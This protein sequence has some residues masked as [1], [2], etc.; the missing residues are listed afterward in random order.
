MLLGLEMTAEVVL[1]GS[2]KRLSSWGFVAVICVVV[3]LAQPASARHRTPAPNT[4]PTRDA[5]LVVDGANG[6]VLYARN[7]TVER[8]PASLT[9]MMTLY[10]IFERLRAGKLK[11][12]TVLTV[13]HNAAVQ[14]KAKLY[15][16]SGK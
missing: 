15:L 5:E 14:P 7:E 11:M 4:D 3:G 8:H 6:T 13:S 1:R 9:K 16:H 2:C 10:V 12:G